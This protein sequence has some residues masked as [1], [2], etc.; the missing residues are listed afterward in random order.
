MSLVSEL[1]LPVSDYAT[2]RSRPAAGRTRRHQHP[3]PYRRPDPN[4]GPGPD[5]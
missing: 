1:E 5:V 3:E 4:Q 2:Q